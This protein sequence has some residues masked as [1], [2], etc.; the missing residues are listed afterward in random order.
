MLLKKGYSIIFFYFLRKN[1]FDRL[2]FKGV[3][4]IDVFF[5]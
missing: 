1:G 3:I 4:L 2:V 5:L